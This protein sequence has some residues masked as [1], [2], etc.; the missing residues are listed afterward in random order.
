MFCASARTTSCT[1]GGFLI[2]GAA[3][4]ATLQTVVPRALL[5]CLAGS[6]P[7]AVLAL[8]LL[9]VVMA[10]C[11]EAD[12]FVAASLKQFSPTAQLVFM[13]VGPMVDVKLV[14]MQAGTFGRAFAVRF[15]PLT[16]VVAVAP[17]RSSAGGCCDR[18][19]HADRPGRR[20]VLRLTSTGAYQRYVQIGMRPWLL[21]AGVAL[22][23]VGAF[24]LVRSTMA[25][26]S[27]GRRRAAASG[28]AAARPD[29][30]AAAGCARRRWA[31][32]ASTAAAPVDVRSGGGQFAPL[33]QGRSAGGDVAAGVR[34]TCLRR[35]RPDRP[36]RHRVAH[37]IRRRRRRRQH[38]FRLA[39]YQIACCAADAAAMS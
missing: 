37:R 31:A 6:G 28:L 39:R 13:V 11:S 20:L 19:G 18:G 2:I 9:A 5:D 25:P 34:A 38:V 22:V 29:C 21:L 7:L 36:R 3:T 30:G 10:I 16:F 15:A 14:A 27:A 33:P 23:A 24:T 12:A 8:A 4:A 32:T 35:R 1:P 26:S 17:R